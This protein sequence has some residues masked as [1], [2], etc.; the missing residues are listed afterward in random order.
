MVEQ[1]IPFAEFLD[2]PESVFDQVERGH[3]AVIIERQGQ[4][5]RLEPAHMLPGALQIPKY[6][7]E[8]VHRALQASAGAFAGV[9]CEQLLADIHAARGQDSLGR[10]AD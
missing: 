4:L 2:H 9:D 10:P 6:D 3:E 8:Q 5:Y 7:T 1:R